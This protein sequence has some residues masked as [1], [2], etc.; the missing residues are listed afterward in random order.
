M[1]PYV[2]SF[3]VGFL[4]SPW[5]LSF[6]FFITWLI[7]YEAFYCLQCDLFRD[8]KKYSF[9]ERLILIGIAI[10]G[11]FIGR[12]FVSSPYEDIGIKI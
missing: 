1:F 11:W 4:L 7:A 5:S 12:F 3:V 6:F 8:K 10:I 9:K 2:Y